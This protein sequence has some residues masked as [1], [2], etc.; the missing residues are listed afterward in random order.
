MENVESV[1]ISSKSIEKSLNNIKPANAVCEY[2]WNGFDAY[3]TKINITTSKNVLGRI[4]ALSVSDNGTGI[5]FDELKVKFQTYNDSE[6]FREKKSFTHHSLPHGKSGVGRFT[7]FLFS[8]SATWETVYE[9]ADKT[10]EK[11][12]IRMRSD[13]LNNYN[14]NDNELPI[15]TDE[16]IGTTVYFDSVFGLTEEELERAIK[17]NFFWFIELYSE[18][19]MQISLNGKNLNFSEMIYEKHALDISELE[20]PNIFSI[21][22]IQ[23]KESLGGEYSKYYYINADGEEV[24]KEYTTL[25]NKSDSFYHSVYIKSDYFNSFDFK[26]DESSG[27]LGFIS[28][29]NDAE[30]K[31]LIQYINNFLISERKAFLKKNSNKFIARLIDNKAFPLFE[32][33]LIDNYRK[34]QLYNIVETLYVAEP[35]IFTG[36]NNKQQKILI[37]MLNMV[38]DGN[39]KDSFFN[40]I[41]EVI[42]LD[43]EE[44]N[45]LSVALQYTTLSNITKTIKLLEDRVSV[46]QRLKELVFN[47]DLNAYEVPHIQKMVEENYW[48]FGEQYHLVTAAE[49]D[50]EE[51][52]RRLLYIKT[53]VNEAVKLDH[54]DAQKEMDI[55]M[56]R[57]DKE[58]EYYNNIVVELKRP[59]IPLGEDELSQVKK[60]MRVIMSDDRFNSNNSTWTYYL[61]GNKYNQNGYIDSEIKSHEIHG[62]RNL[63]HRDKNQ[64]IFIYKWSEVFERFSTRNQYLLDKLKLKE[65]LWLKTHA[66]AD[67]VVSFSLD[68]TSKLSPLDVPKKLAK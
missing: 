11:Y 45:D 25:N 40:I 18:R 4:D 10:K 28:N 62:E 55:F 22:I 41:N 51:A 23:W 24:Y 12:T 2:I 47:K 26:E 33:N 57:Q 65:E 34:E 17:Q 20:L 67:D 13:S 5:N 36:L 31:A 19:N 21:D 37:R 14:P 49:P 30:F 29:K 46:I 60:Y 44:L 6:K 63:V 32:K 3:A 52:L 15:K 16:S 61:V 68:N 38:M 8:Q 1:L 64:K 35:K 58:K 7:F 48:L 50:F 59:S 42:E 9:K 39:D 54:M 53:G 56:V 66:S 27:Q 43:S